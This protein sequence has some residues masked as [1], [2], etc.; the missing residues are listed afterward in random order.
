MYEKG[1]VMRRG[2]AAGVAVSLAM[3]FGPAV[4]AAHGG[5]E[6]KSLHG[7]ETVLPNE[8]S[9]ALG[10]FATE[11]TVSAQVL[12]ETASNSQNEPLT[13]ADQLRKQLV[14]ERAKWHAEKRRLVVRA[15]A[16]QPTIEMAL[17][18]AN[19]TYGVPINGLRALGRCES[20]ETPSAQNKTALSGSRASGYS[21]ILYNPR[22]IASSTWHT[23]PYAR[24]SPFDITANVLAAGYIWF[25]NDNKSRPGFGEW[26]D[27]C[28]RIADAVSGSSVRIPWRTRN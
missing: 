7:S 28:T 6:Q 11:Q 14:H 25:R 2:V 1:E 4:N 24:L 20:N 3:A 9:S 10:S 17:E 27:R 19:A 16:K 12:Q 15:N 5:Q 22:G 21:Q 18:L 26:R 13:E 23:T 8:A